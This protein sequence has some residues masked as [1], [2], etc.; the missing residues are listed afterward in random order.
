MSDW[1]GVQSSI[2]QCVCVCVSV[3]ELGDC[4]GVCSSG[5][6]T[7]QVHWVN[8]A[9]WMLLHVQLRTHST[10]PVS[11]MGSG[12]SFAALYMF[13]IFPGILQH[14]SGT[15]TC[16]Y[17]M[18]QEV[19]DFFTENIESHWKTLDPSDPKDFT[20]VFLLH[21]DKVRAAPDSEQG[22]GGHEKE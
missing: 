12:T 5:R 9:L 6:Y 16:L 8:D 17:S 2:H 10:S 7:L 15:H 13:E 11:T 4:V 3:G 14:F 20:D 1:L 21:M 22:R 19:K 18:L